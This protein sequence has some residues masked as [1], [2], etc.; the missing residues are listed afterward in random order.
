MQSHFSGNVGQNLVTIRKLDTE[1]GI[2]KQ[3]RYRA[4]NF[5]GFFVSHW[6]YR[7]D[8]SG[9]LF[10]SNVVVSLNRFFISSDVAESGR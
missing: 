2:G 5:N 3:F 1:H 7:D 4:F 8:G 6:I 10:F 9:R